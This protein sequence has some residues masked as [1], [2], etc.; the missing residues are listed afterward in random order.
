MLL[1]VL[2]LIFFA[3][4]PL[5]RLRILPCSLNFLT[6]RH[7]VFLS[8]EFLSRN[9]S[10]KGSYNLSTVFRCF[11]FHYDENSLLYIQLH[12]RGLQNDEINKQINS[13]RFKYLL[14][15]RMHFCEII[16]TVGNSR[17]W[18][19]KNTSVLLQNFPL[20]RQFFYLF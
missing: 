17:Y 18:K 2:W 15:S 6:V 1:S 14:V 13:R 11:I 4:F 7:T 9:L 12:L 19:M 16:L 3:E 5:F 10:Q 8:G 20:N